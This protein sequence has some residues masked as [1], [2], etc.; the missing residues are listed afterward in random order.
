MGAAGIAGLVAQG[1]WPA[2][3]EVMTVWAPEYAALARSELEMRYDQ[4]LH[5][6]P[7]WSLLVIPTA[8]LAVLSIIDA[9][10]WTAR[11]AADGPG[12]IGRILP[13]WLWDR[14]ADANA[15]FAR[16]ALAALYLV[17]AAQSFLIQ[18]GFMYVHM[19]E[20]LFMFGLWAA[21]CWCLPAAVILYVALTST[22]WVIGDQSWKVRYRLYQ[23]ARHDSRPASDP[24]HEHYFMRHPLADLRAPP[25]LA[26]VLARGPHRSRTLYP[27]GPAEA[28]DRPR[29]RVLVGGAR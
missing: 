23:I 13:G 19:A 15:R 22:F 8:V 25:P 6:F 12:P 26:P 29:G 20:L 4:E 10:P 11:P 24:D 5:W 7:P 1:S 9:A 27:V 28:P 14:E 18:R 2:F 21:H 16:A 17:W 3:W